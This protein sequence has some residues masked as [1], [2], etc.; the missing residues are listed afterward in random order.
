V[1]FTTSN[2]IGG[3]NTT[4]F[5]AFLTLSALL[6]FATILTLIVFKREKRLRAILT[7]QPAASQD[8]NSSL[9]DS[10]NFNLETQPVAGSNAKDPP[11]F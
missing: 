11:G 6:L 2:L 8:V 4:M 7:G 5:L 10:E 3:R 9:N 1:V